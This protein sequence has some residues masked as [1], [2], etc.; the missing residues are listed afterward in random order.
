MDDRPGGPP[1]SPGWGGDEG[2]GCAGRTAAERRGGAGA[3]PRHRGRACWRGEARR[4]GGFADATDEELRALE[5]QGR[6][7]WQP[8]RPGQPAAGGA[9]RRPDRRPQPAARGRPVPGGLPGPD[10]GRRSASTTAAAPR[11]STYAL[12]WVRSAVGGVSAGHLGALNLPTSRAEQ[13]RAARGVEAELTQQ[14]GRPPTADE[15]AARPRP[16]RGLDAGAAGARR[17][18][19]DRGGR[20]RAG[21]ARRRRS[22]PTPRP[23]VHALLAALDPLTRQVLELRCG[24]G[25]GEPLSLAATG[26]G[27]ASRPA[28]SAGWSSGAGGAAGRLPP[29]RR[30]VPERLTGRPGRRGRMGPWPPRREP[31]WWSRSRGLP[32]RRAR[33]LAGV[34]A[35][36]AR[37]AP[38]R[39][40]AWA[41]EDDRLVVGSPAVLSTGGGAGLAARRLARDR[42]GRLERRA[43]PA[44]LGAARRPSRGRSSWPSPAGCPSCSAS[45]SRP[46]SSSASSSP[47]PATAASPSAPAAPLGGGGP[48]VWHTSLTRGLSWQ[49]PGVREAVDDA[50]AQT[51]AEYDM[52]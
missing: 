16:Q 1:T 22:P 20:R 51:R 4:G 40:L 41:G 7:A 28:A 23:E 45:G 46:P 24:F 27:W 42:A 15:L 37:P 18:D 6:R 49:T 50:L 17:P 21:R 33:R 11:F 10:G 31:A 32:G 30:L 48:L 43:A 12:F 47:W 35:R 2:P 34:A 38:P 5:E 8:L 39:I 14:L 26:R 19:A 44:Q 36:G 9:G 13:L 52:R 25:G 29:G 3:R